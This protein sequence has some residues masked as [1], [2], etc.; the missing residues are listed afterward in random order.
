MARTIKPAALGSRT[1]RARLRRRRQPH[2]NAIGA[3]IHLG[4]VRRPAERAGRWILRR[5]IRGRYSTQ[6][7]G[8]ADDAIEAGPRRHAL[9]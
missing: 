3:K 5:R 7:I 2:W 8:A 9:V 6:T 1:A 4:Y